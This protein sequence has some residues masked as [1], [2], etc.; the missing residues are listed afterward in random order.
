[1]KECVLYKK[2]KSKKGN[3]KV[4]CL[5]CSHK[6][7]IP[8]GKTGICG[9]R[10]NIEGKLYLLV[11]GKLIS[12]A[13]D[14][15]EKKPLYHFLPHSYAFSIATIGC[16]FKC[17]WCFHPET[18]IFTDKGPLKIINIF[19]LLNNKKQSIKVIT[20][21]GIYK[22]VL[23]VFRRDYNEELI[24]IKPA[25]T[26]EILCSKEHNLFVKRQNKLEKIKATELKK[27]DYLA[28]PKIKEMQ[29]SLKYL[30][31]KELLKDNVIK[32]KIPIRIT[33]PIYND[34]LNLKKEG[35]TSKQI[36]EKYGIHPSY[37]RTFFSKIKKNPDFPFFREISLV[38]RGNY[39]KFVGEKGKGIKKNIEIDKDFAKL[40]GFFC[41]EGHVHKFKD[42]PNSYHIEFSLNK[43]EEDLANEISDLF[44][45]VFEVKL[46]KVVRRTGLSVGISSSSIG[47]L[48]KKLC[49]TGA[50]NKRLPSFLFS[51]SKEIILEFLRAYDKGDGW[52][53]DGNHPISMDTVSKDLALGIY[54]LLLK[55]NFLPAFY[56]WNPFPQKDIEGRRV[57]QSTL[58]YIKMY[59]EQF[60]KRF[61][62]LSFDGK[63][64][65]RS[66]GNKKFEED[67]DYFYIPIQKI[68]IQDYSGQVY[69]IEVEDDH[70]YLANFISVANCQ[71][72]DI[73]QASKNIDGREAIIIGKE[74]SPMQIVSLAAQNKCQSVAYTYSEPV[75]AS[76][77]YKEICEI[78]HGKGMKNV[79][80]TNGYF[81]KESL[82]YFDYSENISKNGKKN[83]KIKRSLIDAMNIDLKSFDDK[84][85]V[86]YC[87]ATKG[88]KPVLDT[89]KRAYRKGVHIEITT[90]IVPEINDNEKELKQI[91]KFIFNVDKKGNIPWHISRFFPMYKFAD[92]KH[93]ITPLETLER[94]RKIGEKAGL[95]YVY[96]GNV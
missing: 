58:Y 38:E 88:I 89:I 45:R 21:K 17:D 28:I 69:N 79:F 44:I 91:A 82:D 47:L 36:G 95:K 5:A 66:E 55:L 77:F 51:C 33:A 93:E 16:N 46:N 61:Y 50:K 19:D 35:F 2:E 42:R 94:A 71:N 57:N 26:P 85:Y 56:T 49:E 23:N 86:K 80:V 1:M 34:L 39:I 48:F 60:R 22:R 72:F 76:E 18:I 20:H 3:K 63:I 30:D 12:L 70:S 15:I 96:V 27:G 10:K 25:Y 90:L 83:K 52:S 59:A 29:N 14:P 65:K 43:Q 9:V 92:G 40:L 84:T 13:V 31:T 64:S 11:Y 4:R 68:E 7:L 62:D 78:A 6:C 73:S 37:V 67:S 41:A 54:A 8:L 81:T 24:K 32:T 74:F 53:G 87:G 75:I